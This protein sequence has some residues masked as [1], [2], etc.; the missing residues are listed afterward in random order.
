MWRAGDADPNRNI[1]PKLDRRKNTQSVRFC[2][3]SY[4]DPASAP[5]HVIANSCFPLFVV[6][7]L[8]Q[9]KNTWRRVPSWLASCRVVTRSCIRDV[10]L[11]EDLTLSF[12]IVGMAALKRWRRAD[13]TAS[14]WLGKCSVCVCVCVRQADGPQL[15]QSVGEWFADVSVA[16]W[17]AKYGRKSWCGR[18]SHIFRI[19]IA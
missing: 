7:F 11:S 3:Q 6:Y 8:E 15:V 16:N 1:S 2:S 19:F 17:A 12:V 18:P 4:V 5:R 14:G 9:R 10:C 13:S